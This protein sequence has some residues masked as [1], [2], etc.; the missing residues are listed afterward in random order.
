MIIHVD[1]N[2]LRKKKGVT[3]KTPLDLLIPIIHD[4]VRHETACLLL[5]DY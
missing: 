1:H 5:N 3:T 2:C 4:T